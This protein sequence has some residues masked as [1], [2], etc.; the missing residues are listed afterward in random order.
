MSI[1]PAISVIAE[2]SMVVGVL[3][4]RGSVD[5]YRQ[6]FEMIRANAGEFIVLL[7]LRVDMHRSDAQTS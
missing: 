2:G 6:G 7:L 1:G 4:E 5:A 3:D